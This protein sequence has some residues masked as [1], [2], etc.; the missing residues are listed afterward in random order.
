MLPGRPFVDEQIGVGQSK[1]EHVRLLRCCRCHL[2]RGQ[3]SMRVR[4]RSM[5]PAR[6]ER[7]RGQRN[8]SCSSSP[9]CGCR[10]YNLDGTL[11]GTK[12]APVAAAANQ[13]T[14]VLTL[15]KPAGLSDVHFIRLLLKDGQQVVSENFYWDGNKYEKY[16][17]LNTLPPIQLEL[18]G[19]ARVDGDETVVSVTC[20]MAPK[21][22]RLCLGFCWCAA[23]QAHVCCPLIIR[24]TISLFYPANLMSLLYA[25][26]RSI[27]KAR[28]L[29]SIW[30]DIMFPQRLLKF[31]Q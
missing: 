1:L 6:L 17:A 21:R 11:Q 25:A 3:E 7:Q 16:D 29:S 30:M 8:A 18:S 2:F 22:S 9:H 15:D 14:A 19:S 24:T 26:K 12:T 28:I 4:A 23:A 20:I 13:K 27:C 5:G 31:P 10:G